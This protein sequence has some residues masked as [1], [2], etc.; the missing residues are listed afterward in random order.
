MSTTF[1]HVYPD[2]AV[3]CETDP[4]ERPDV[5]A[6]RE[7]DREPPPQHGR[8][9]RN[10]QHRELRADAQPRPRAEREVSEPVTSSRVLR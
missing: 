3:G 1:G 9:E 7:P 6:G 4:R 10:F 8:H 2:W 5:L